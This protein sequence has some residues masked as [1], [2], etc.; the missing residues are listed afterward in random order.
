VSEG[1]THAGVEL[2]WR[3]FPHPAIPDGHTCN[4]LWTSVQPV[5]AAGWLRDIWGGIDSSV[6]HYPAEMLV[7][8]YAEDPLAGVEWPAPLTLDGFVA[9]LGQAIGWLAPLGD[10]FGFVVGLPHPSVA[11]DALAAGT[12]DDTEGDAR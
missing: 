9:I 3:A 5:R 6:F 4:L 12:T 1:G 8:A 2:Q 11:W 10:D 7:A